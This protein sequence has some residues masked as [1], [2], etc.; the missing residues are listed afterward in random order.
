M[1][2]HAASTHQ[3]LQKSFL[4]IIFTAVSKVLTLIAYII[5]ASQI[6]LY[7]SCSIFILALPPLRLIRSC[8]DMLG[9][10]NGCKVL[11]THATKFGVCVH[12]IQLQ[13]AR[14]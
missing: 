1:H 3:Y 8:L 2:G 13:V 14:S 5:T 11:I 9:G 6:H 12:M 10:A 4:M 7:C